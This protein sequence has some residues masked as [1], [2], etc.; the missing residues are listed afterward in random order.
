[1]TL[2]AHTGHLSRR[3]SAR[4]GKEA[5]VI[6][7]NTLIWW[8]RHGLTSSLGSLS[9]NAAARWARCGEGRAEGAAGRWRRISPGG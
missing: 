3:R 8:R 7:A 4:A 2:P 5:R 9:E 1:M 6:F